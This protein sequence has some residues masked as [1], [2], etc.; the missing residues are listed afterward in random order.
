M[1]NSGKIMHSNLLVRR[2]RERCSPLSPL[3]SDTAERLRYLPDIRCVAFDFYGTMF[4]SGT[5][6]LGV[7]GEPEDHA[8]RARRALRSADI[9]P[10]TSRDYPGETGR[11]AIER[12]EERLSAFEESRRERGI[13]HPEPDIG[14]LWHRVLRD[15]SGEGL[16]ENSIG[17]E[18]ARLFALEFE[19][20]VNEVWPAPGL[21][22]VIGELRGSRD[23]GIISNSQFYTPLTFRALTGRSPE[24]MGFDPSLLIWSYKV[25]LKKPSLDFYRHFTRRLEKRDY[26]PRQVLYVGNDIRRDVAPARKL[27]MKTALYAGDRRSVRHDRGEPQREPFKADLILTAL[28]QL[29]SCLD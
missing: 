12:F 13:R 11:R 25:G 6:G 23:L 16:L 8:E 9:K 20:Q 14:E 2:I 1:R 27:G 26:E 19:L 10:G 15:L 24:E 18:K 29:L 3:P 7:E 21:E 28:P 5:G 22:K 17:G 4:L